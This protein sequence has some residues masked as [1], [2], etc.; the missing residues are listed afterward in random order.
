MTQGVVDNVRIYRRA[1]TAAEIRSL[2]QENTTGTTYGSLTLVSTLDDHYDA[3]PG[4]YHLTISLNG[5]PIY[6]SSLLIEH[7]QPHQSQFTNFAEIVIPFDLELLKAGE[8]ELAISL[9][10]A[11]ADYDWF[12]WDYAVLDDGQLR[13]NIESKGRVGLQSYGVSVVYSGR[14]RVFQF[15]RP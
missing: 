1:L 4:Q 10:G 6:D 7:G 2:Y 13:Q 8:N 14:S 9:R 3:D 5:A 15:D 12:C 11:R